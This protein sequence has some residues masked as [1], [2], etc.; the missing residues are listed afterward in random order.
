MSFQGG[1]RPDSCPP[2][3]YRYNPN[4][5]PGSDGGS[6]GVGPA[7]SQVFSG[8][9]TSPPTAQPV[10]P[11]PPLVAGT[12]LSPVEPG[13]V[14]GDIAAPPG[15]LPLVSPSQPA[16]P[17]PTA[18]LAVPTMREDGGEGEPDPESVQTPSF[19]RHSPPW[20]V[21]MLF[22]MLVLII[23]G[24]LFLPGM[25]M[26][27]VEV[28]LS[29]AEDLG[30]QQLDDS[31]SLVPEEPMDVP[32]PIFTP[33]DLAPVD[34]PLAAP[35]EMDIHLRANVS[36]SE[37]EASVVS[38]ALTGREKGMKRALLL[39]YGGDATTEAAVKR[40][41][42][43][44]KRNQ[45]RDGSWSLKGPYSNSGGVENKTA[46]TALALLA[47]QGA[48][49]T[50]QGGE[51]QKVVINGWR[52]MMKMQ[53]EDGDFW[54]GGP[55]HHRLYSQAQAT[56]ALC[57]LY[58]MTRDEKYRK[59]AQRSIDY[60]VKIQDRQGGWR[61]NPG[62][63]SDTSVTGWFVMALQSA[64]MAGL[65]VDSE[66]L[67]KVSQFL[68]STASEGRSRNGYLPGSGG[69]VVMTAEAMLCRQ[70]MGWKHE[71]P[72]LIS[73]V[74][75]IDANPIEF[76]NAGNVYYWY[77]ATQVVHHME[78]EP[79]NRWNA[80]MKRALP[81]HQVKEGRERGSWSPTGDRYG[82]N[83]GRLYTTALCT[84]MLEVYYRH[85]PI[86]SEVYK[87]FSG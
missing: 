58:G 38:L 51:Y 35:A 9:Q 46:A 43:W 69:G 56:I 61:Y 19:F 78:G 8:P 22:H 21:S 85:L 52:A 55:T 64:R 34:N 65:Q 31:V 20:L 4:P 81:E 32:E 2:P 86:Y 67:E 14:Q 23:A 49:H 29:Y 13:S 70:Y 66:C 39:A 33:D 24:I 42:A 41:L 30:E 17:I 79:W 12:A 71:D 60:A 47:F 77:Y 1:S 7:P 27:Q 48:G 26:S 5:L 76:N 18:L 3:D 25:L 36:T 84:Y 82:S 75:Y 87:Y 40:A 15:S 63:G 50:H 54:Q 28:E 57:E 11:L 74:D 80:V 6:S 68:D 44:F 73:A 72:R 10:V 45:D 62:S 83:G 37:M 53:N 16:T 59:P